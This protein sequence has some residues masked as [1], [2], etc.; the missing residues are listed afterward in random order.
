MWLA[1]MAIVDKMLS[2]AV[3]WLPWQLKRSDEAK[4]KHDAA[5]ADMDKAAEMGSFDA[6]KKA[7]HDRDTA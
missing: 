5:Q 3:S 6:W 1:I 2:L 4:K 7:R